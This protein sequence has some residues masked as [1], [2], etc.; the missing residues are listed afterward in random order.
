MKKKE[1]ITKIKQTLKMF[2]EN[3]KETDNNVWEEGYLNGWEDAVNTI[4]DLMEKNLDNDKCCDRYNGDLDVT[5]SC[6]FCKKYLGKSVHNPCPYGNDDCP[7]C[8]K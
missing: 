3:F 7:K 8:K 6:I 5:G 1:F 2:K 4:V